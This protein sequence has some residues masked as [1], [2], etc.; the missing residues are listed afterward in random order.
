[1]SELYQRG[2]H[3]IGKDGKEDKKGKSLFEA[4]TNNGGALSELIRIVR[5]SPEYVLLI[6]DDYFNIY[7][8][9]GNV[10]KVSS[11]QCV[12]FDE[13]YFR[14]HKNKEDEEWTRIREKVKS[15]KAL[16]KH[17]RFQEYLDIVIPAMENYF[18]LGLKGDE[19]K[20][21]QHQLCLQNTFESKSDYTILDLEYEVSVRSPFAY[22]GKRRVGK[23]NDSLPQPRF[24]IVAVRKSDGKICIMELK[25]G[26]KALRRKS[27][28]GEHAES[29]E[30]SVGHSPDTMKTFADEM[31]GILS[32]MQA[33]KLI[34]NEVSI[35]SDEV[36][37][38]FVMQEKDNDPAPDQFVEFTN[39]FMEE[40]RMINLDPKYG[41]IKLGRDDFQLKFI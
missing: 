40:L 14:A 32:Q 26:T 28:I 36:E 24:D 1:M 25:K 17:G 4:L 5:S 23:N 11:L 2:L 22:C 12:E 34:S 37:Y 6:R 30:N 33:M 7:Y 35:N 27:G 29:F 3:L 16:F 41:I 10:A 38:M 13:N 15:T 8:R 9:G 18:S 20:E 39:A 31:R 19:E 21:C